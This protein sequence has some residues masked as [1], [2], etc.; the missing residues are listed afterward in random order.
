MFYTVRAGARVK[1][2][3]QKRGCGQPETL[4]HMLQQCYATHLGRI[5]RHGNLVKYIQK[6][7]QDRGITVHREVQFKIDNKLY[8]PDLI[9]YTT[10]RVHAVDIQ[11]IND[12]FPLQTAHITKKQKYEPLKQKLGGLRPEGFRLPSRKL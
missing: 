6:I 1:T 11:I 10:D 3:G 4:N 2:K 8:K 12:Q 7:T 5:K 9:L